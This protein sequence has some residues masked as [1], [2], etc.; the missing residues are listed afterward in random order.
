MS[1]PLDLYYNP[2]SGPCRLVMLVAK[3]LGIDEKINV[4]NVDLMQ[5]EH[6]KP[7]FLAVNPQHTVPTLV[8][9]ENNFTVWESRAIASYLI[10]KYKPGSLIPNDI[11]DRATI[12]RHLF[13]DASSLSPAVSAIYV[14]I[15]RQNKKPEEDKKTA[16]KDKLKHL[17]AEVK[18]KKYIVGNSLTLADLSYLVTCGLIVALKS[19][20]GIEAEEYPN[21]VTYLK[22]L[23]ESLPYYAE[24]SEEA[25]AKF[26]GFIEA[27]YAEIK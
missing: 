12:A 22:G 26:K 19:I 20:I 6:L 4:K 5:G 16:L 7:E 18:D 1:K 17:D 8:D 10:T 25:A 23:K 3:E 27:K 14:P 24:V 13:F 21:L 9:N 15:F 11:K 2:M